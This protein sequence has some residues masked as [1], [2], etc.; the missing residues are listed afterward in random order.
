MPLFDYECIICGEMTERLNPAN[1]ETIMCPKCGANARKI[2]SGSTRLPDDAEWLKTV[3]DVVDK[4]N[5]SPHVQEF[6]RHPTRSNYRRWMK[7]EGIRP[8]ERGERPR[9]D[10]S[11][12]MARHREEVIRKHFERKKITI[13]GR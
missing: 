6:I 11:E 1:V 2:I 12:D 13:G 9:R 8:L 4:E 7:S 5:P 10:T 3:I